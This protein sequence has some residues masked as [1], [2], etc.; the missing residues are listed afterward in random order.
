MSPL[1]LCQVRH[2]R[3]LLLF[4]TLSGLLFHVA[5]ARAQDRYSFS[6]TVLLDGGNPLAGAGVFFN[7]VVRLR[8]TPSG[9]NVPGEAVV[10]GK[11][12]SGPDGTFEV[13]N[14]PA[15]KYV[16]C[17]TGTQLNHL[18]SCNWGQRSSAVQVG[19]S[20]GATAIPAEPVVLN[21]RSGAVLTV[22]ID[23]PDQLIQVK[24]ADGI[25]ARRTTVGIS[26]VSSA[27]AYYALRYQGT[28]GARWSYSVAIPI[29]APV[30]LFIDTSL[31]I[32]DQSGQPI[33]LRTLSMTVQAEDG[34]GVT[35]TMTARPSAQV[36]R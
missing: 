7:R 5:D 31:I 3:L 27:N 1:G 26:A 15:G 22:N 35:V 28:T 9:G 2:N 17:A 30:R 34:N 11:V 20:E 6:G 10:S 8:T 13:S 19:A 25:R 18:P 21:V 33:S 36:N 24:D 4:C 14:I 29:G 32:V 12:F 23:D 16:I